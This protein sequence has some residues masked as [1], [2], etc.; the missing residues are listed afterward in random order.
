MLHACEVHMLHLDT[1]VPAA[2]EVHVRVQARV[3]RKR[4][5]RE[6]A[7]HLERPTLNKS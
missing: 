7:E 6:I 2:V 4:L 1:V 5:Q 3:A